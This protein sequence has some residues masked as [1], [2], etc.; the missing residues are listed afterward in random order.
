[1]NLHQIVT[2]AIGAVHPNETVYLL[3]S[4]GQANIKGVVT[5]TYDKPRFVKAQVQSLSGDDLQQVDNTLRTAITRK[6]YLFSDPLKPAG[7]IRPKSRTG[8][9]LK[10]SDSTIWRVFNVS[11]DFDAAGWVLVFAALQNDVEQQVK[12]L[13]NGNG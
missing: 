2:N 12:D 9:F 8:D 7:Q 10:R 11:E 1:M 4:T 13:F 6:F 5:A 3:Q